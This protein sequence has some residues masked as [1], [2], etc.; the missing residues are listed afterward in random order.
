MDA[1]REAK[2]GVT[3]WATFAAVVTLAIAFVFF[4]ISY[5][6]PTEFLLALS[7]LM[8]GVPVSLAPGIFGARYKRLER[9]L[10]T[11]EKRLKTIFYVG[12]AIFFVA[13]IFR[14]VSGIR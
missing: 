12:A 14:L 7:V 2:S 9:P 6:Q 8:M 5:S 1:S 13:L 4:G 3:S 10:S 11:N